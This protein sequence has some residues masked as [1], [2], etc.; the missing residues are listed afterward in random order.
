MDELY[1]QIESLNNYFNNLNTILKPDIIFQIYSPMSVKLRK[2]LSTIIHK[3]GNISW[4]GEYIQYYE[5]NDD[6]PNDIEITKKTG[7]ITVQKTKKHII[8]CD[9]TI[10]KTDIDVP[11]IY[12]FGGM[13][14]YMI[15]DYLTEI[16]NTKKMK[17]LNFIVP[18]SGDYDFKIH[19][20]DNVTNFSKFS[21]EDSN[22][23]NISRHP[24]IDNIL[25]QIMIIVAKTLSTNIPTKTLSIKNFKF[26]F[27]NYL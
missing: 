23:E 7:T 25:K 13:N 14:W 2:S 26:L 18:R 24:E 16:C 11:N 19:L 21:L 15:N 4:T 27:M 6:D 20:V 22:I 10:T 5:V 9:G 12:L 17:N 3:I 8:K 1:S